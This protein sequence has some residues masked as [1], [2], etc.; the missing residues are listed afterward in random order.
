MPVN[1]RTL[2]TAQTTLTE[3]FLKGMLGTSA[4]AME[5]L[6]M[7]IDMQTKTVEAPIASMVG[8]LREWVGPRMIQELERNAYSITAK[9]FEGTVGVPRTAIDDDLTGSY[10]AAFETLGMQVSA[11]PDQQLAAKLEAGET[12]LCLDGV[13]FVNAAHPVERGSSTTYSNLTGAGQVA[14]Y[15]FDASRP[16]KPLVWG[17]RMRPE[18]VDLWNPDDPNVFKLNKYISGVYARGVADYGLPQLAHKCKNTLDQ[19]NFETCLTSMTTRVNSKGE[20]LMVR[21]TH[22]Y[23]PAILEPK[24]K[25]LFGVETLANGAKNPWYQ[26]VTVVVGQRLSNV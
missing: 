15:L 1:R 12:D 8:P 23:V 13:S 11:W 4:P 6:A 3:A 16:I 17:D 14:W 22:I 5:L 18:K 9:D 21:P 24:A 25:A 19:T 10:R 20:N 7:R 2:Q 26:A